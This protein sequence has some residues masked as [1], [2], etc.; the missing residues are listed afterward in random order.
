MMIRRA[1]LA[2]VLLSLLAACAGPPASP[3]AGPNPTPANPATAGQVFGTACIQQLPGFGGT[4]A[5]LTSFAFTQRQSSGI[6][7]KN[8]ENLSVRLLSTASG[9]ACAVTF[10]TNV[11]RDQAVQ[12]FGQAASAAAPGA[13]ADIALDVGRG[14]DGLLYFTATTRA[15]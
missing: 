10:G 14:A 11:G 15:Q 3:T 13:Q 2:P 8:D 9:P 5:A 1:A 7:Y 6:Y 4:P 12:A